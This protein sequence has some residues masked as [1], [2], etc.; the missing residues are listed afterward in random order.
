MISACALVRLSASPRLTSSW[1]ARTLATPEPPRHRRCCGAALS[2][3]SRRCAARSSRASSYCFSGLSCS[4]KRS[5]SRMVRIFRPPSTSPSSL[6]SV[7]TCAPS[8][9]IDASSTV[10]ATS[11]VVSSLRISALSSGLAKRRSATVVDRPF[12]SSSS[13]AF[14]A[15]ASRVPSDRIA[16]VLPSRTMRP[17]PISSAC[18]VD[19]KRQSPALA[20]RI[21][22]RDR[23]AVVQRHGVDHVAQLDLVGRGHHR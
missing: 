9:P 20:A 5:G 6:A 10:T 11:C 21:A 7:S 16:T 19:R 18:G 3:P 12:A 2:A 13:A 1:S 22:H 14:S 4:W 17:L 15:S 8:P 23:A